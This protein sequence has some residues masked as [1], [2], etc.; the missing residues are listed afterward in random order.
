MGGAGSAF[1]G[2]PIVIVGG[3]DYG[4]SSYP[5]RTFDIDKATGALTQRGSDVDAGP[6]PSY[7]ALGPSGRVLYVANE[8]DDAAGGLTAVAMGDDG[9]LTFLN[10]QTGSDGG[11]TYV[12][13]DPSGSYALGA[14][15]NGGSVSVFPI[16]GDGS[17]G[18]EL[19]S[20]D[21]GDGAQSHAVGFVATGGFV[22]VPNKGNDE[23]AQLVLGADGML[24]DNTP[25]SVASGAGAGPRHIALDPNGEFAFVINELDSSLTSYALSMSGTLTAGATVSTLPDGFQGQN[26]GAHVELSPNGR[27]LYASNRGHDSIA[28]FEVDATSGALS[29]L[30]HE[31]T[32]GS[33]PR[34]FE[35]DPAGDVLVVANQDSGTLAVFAVAADGNLSP[36]GDPVNG[37]PSPAAVQFVYLE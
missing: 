4:S 5:L 28:V 19:E 18:A 16:E 7:L 2:T 32:R 35:T 1:T 27:F 9:A 36:L 33:T 13:V 15:Y 23:V 17:L 20:R 11:F 31:P 29:L 10:H 26:S 37:P 3:Y 25:G 22:L 6:N 12:A 14:S 8:T 30:E 24:A 21:F 34:G